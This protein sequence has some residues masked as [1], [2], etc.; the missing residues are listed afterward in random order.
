MVID[1]PRAPSPLPTEFLPAERATAEELERQI[2]ILR[3][4]PIVGP[5]LDAVLGFVTVLNRHRQ[6]VLI[7][8][9]LRGYMLSHGLPL[10]VGGR[11]GEMLQCVT[12]AASVGGCGT[13]AAC[14]YCG[15]AHR[16]AAALAGGSGLRECRIRREAAGQDLDLLVRVTPIVL[17]DE[18][19]MIFAA[20]DVSHE[21]RFSISAI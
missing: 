10:E 6:V 18:P 2:T 7:N 5:L 11:P 21:R 12:A 19:F 16:L 8:E 4:S 9:A 17:Q 14:R 20:L 15:A 13:S 1:S 3:T